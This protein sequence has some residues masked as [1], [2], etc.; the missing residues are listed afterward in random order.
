L[1]DE[2]SEVLGLQ[3]CSEMLLYDFINLQDD[4]MFK[5]RREMV[6]RMFKLSKILGEQI[7]TGVIIPVFRKLS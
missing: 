6:L 7:F 3:I 4:P 5:V 2:L 1:L